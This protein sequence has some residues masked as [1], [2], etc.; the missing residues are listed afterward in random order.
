VGLTETS[1]GWHVRGNGAE[2]LLVPFEIDAAQMM[3]GETNPEQGWYCPVFGVMLPAPTLTLRASQ[4][5]FGYAIFPQGSNVV[6][7][8]AVAALAHQVV[9]L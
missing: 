9:G 5:R 4:S 7:S 8:E 1:K 6:S 2:A 3:L